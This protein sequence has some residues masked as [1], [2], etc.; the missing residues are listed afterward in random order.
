MFSY[1]R[2]ARIPDVETQTNPIDRSIAHLLF[3]RP[4]ESSVKHPETPDSPVSSQ[5]SLGRNMNGLM[6]LTMGFVP[7][8]SKNMQSLSHRGSEFTCSLAEGD[9]SKKSPCI[10]SP[11]NASNNESSLGRGIDGEASR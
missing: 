2:F 11:E 8:S 6:S 9:H 1:C 5:L 4:P 3:H 7:E 10:D